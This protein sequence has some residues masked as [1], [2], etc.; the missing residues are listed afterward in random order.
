MT[1]IGSPADV[2]GSG[3]GNLG[4]AFLVTVVL[5]ASFAAAQAAYGET[6]S[7]AAGGGHTCA[8]LAGEA[9]A[10][11]GDGGSGQ[12]GDGSTVSSATPV[13]VQGLTGAKA[14]ATGDA[15]SC[16]ALADGRVECWGDNRSGQLGDGS[17]HGSPLPVGVRGITSATAVS[18]GDQFSCALLSSGRAKCWGNNYDGELGDGLTSD[19][20]PVPVFVRGLTHAVEI[21]SSGGHSC[22]LLTDGDVKCWG[23]DPYGQLGDA[24]PRAVKM[25]GV[26]GA[27]SVAAGGGGIP[28]N[29]AEN[30]SEFTCVVVRQGGVLCWGDDRSGQL[31]DGGGRRASR[32]PIRVARISGATAVS[33]GVQHA[34][35]IVRGGMVK[36]WGADQA[37]E[38]G[39]GSIRPRSFAMAVTGLTGVTDVV[40]GGNFGSAHSCALLADSVECWGDNRYGQLGTGT[41]TGA[42]QPV[43]VLLPSG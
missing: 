43:Q 30:V 20:S 25:R 33:A 2:R 3:F 38:I 12:L 40:A 23:S 4:I 21:T 28:G 7:L 5:G 39:N 11:W 34:C 37:G 41:T 16:A 8:V 35:A 1:T 32:S 22:A 26:S 10:C 42:S 15:Q 18:A 27:T 36:C 14:I 19:P 9:V 17:R 24:M 29:S 6:G 31:G 13:L